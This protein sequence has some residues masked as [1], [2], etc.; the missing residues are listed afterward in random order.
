MSRMISIGMLAILAGAA[1]A[2]DG[3]ARG[4][5]GT[6]ERQTGDTLVRLMIK[7]GDLHIAVHSP[8]A[9]L[10]VGADYGVTKAGVLYGIVTK[11]E[12][13]GT[14]EGPPEGQLFSFRFRVSGETLTVS[15]LKGSEADDFRSWLEGDYKS[16]KK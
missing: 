5:V 3:K 14:E 8:D 2:A 12:K 9:I 10:E 13:K 15:E 4:P 1:P 6:W 7:G 16:M 11:V